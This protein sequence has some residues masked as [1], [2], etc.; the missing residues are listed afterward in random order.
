M[1]GPRHTKLLMNKAQRIV[2]FTLLGSY[3]TKCDDLLS[4]LD[5]GLPH[6]LTGHCLSYDWRVTCH[7]SLLR[8]S[9]QVWSPE[10][11]ARPVFP[12]AELAPDAGLQSALVCGF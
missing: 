9:V 6:S 5:A 3:T 4:E 1:T 7:R 2:R 10:S 12:T 8:S 11:V